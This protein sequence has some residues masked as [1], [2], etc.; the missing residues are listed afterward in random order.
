MLSEG[1]DVEN[2]IAS[3]GSVAETIKCQALEFDVSLNRTRPR[4][5]KRSRKEIPR[6]GVQGAHETRRPGDADVM[7]SPTHFKCLPKRSDR[8][9]SEVP[10]F[11]LV[12]TCLLSL[13]DDDDGEE[14]KALRRI[15]HKNEPTNDFPLLHWRNLLG[16]SQHCQHSH[17]LSAQTPGSV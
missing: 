1:Q 13:G 9:M 3:P 12:S 4:G 17:L 8:W 15:L 14:E 7:R 6:R 5:S 11:K 16:H 2:G 10:C